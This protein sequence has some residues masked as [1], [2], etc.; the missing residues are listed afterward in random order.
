M[1]RRSLLTTWRRKPWRQLVRDK[2]LVDDLKSFLVER[3]SPRDED[4]RALVDR[5][6]RGVR[7]DRVDAALALAARSWNRFEDSNDFA[8]SWA[9]LA[10]LMHSDLGSAIIAQALHDRGQKLSI[11]L[12]TEKRSAMSVKREAAFCRREARN[13]AEELGGVSF[14]TRPAHWSKAFAAIANPPRP[15]GAAEA[16]EPPAPS[17]SGPTR[18]VVSAAGLSNDQPDWIEDPY[19]RLTEPLPL[20]GA[21]VDPEQLRETLLAEFGNLR[22]AIDRIV[23]DLRLRHRAGV[24]FA[25]FRPL[26]LV[27]PPGIGKTRFAKKLAKIFGVGYGEVS[28]AGSSDDRMLRGTARSWRSSQPALPLLVMLRSTCANPLILVDEVEK[29][30]GSDYAGRIQDTLLMMMETETSRT[31]FDEYMEAPADISGVSW[32]LTANSTRGL[33][34]PFLSRIG[35]VHTPAPT[36]EMFD[37]LLAGILRDIAEEL[38]VAVDALPQL[39]PEIR[40]RLRQAFAER[41]DV[42]RIKRAVESAL[43][44]CAPSPDRPTKDEEN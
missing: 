18:V 19:Q 21:E 24:R 22:Q 28:G 29:A 20:K 43:P 44:L 27:G 13:W 37:S 26:L 33:S 10:A 17:F 4:E 23:G 12:G 25:K 32:I 39:A 30:G 36:P 14:L 31:F 40:E 15:F 16:S 3:L 7:D 11:D 2:D 1:K 8:V 38:G 34:G 5:V 35:I 42:R 41:P 9:L 6:L